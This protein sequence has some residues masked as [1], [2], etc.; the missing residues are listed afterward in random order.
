PLQAASESSGALGETPRIVRQLSSTVV[1]TYV[2]QIPGPDG[3]PLLVVV[4]RVARTSGMTDEQAAEYVSAAEAA[5]QLDHPN[6]VRARAISPGA[7][8]ISISCDFV[9]GERLAALWE[10]VVPLEIA[11]RVFI[12][13]LTG[14]SAIHKVK[15]ESGH[16][17]L[18]LIHGEMSAANILVGI[19]GVSRILRMCRVRTAEAFPRSAIG[20]LAPEILS[21]EQ[22]DQRADVFSVGALLWQAL[23]GRPLFA[24]E[25]GPDTI[26]ETIRSGGISRA[27][28]PSGADWAEPLADVTARALDIDPSKRFPTAVAM[29][30]ELRKVGGSRL[31]TTSQV[32]DFVQSVAGEKIAERRAPPRT[33]EETPAPEPKRDYPES[34][35]RIARFQ[36]LPAPAPVESCVQIDGPFLSEPGPSVSI[37]RTL[38]PMLEP[39]PI[40][41]SASS[42]SE[43]PASVRPAPVFTLLDPFEPIL[44]PEAAPPLAE[45]RDQQVVFPAG[46][47]DL[48]PMEAPTANVLDIDPGDVRSV[49]PPL[50]TTE[51]QANVAEGAVA[52][53]V[54]P[55]STPSIIE[56]DPTDVAS[57]PPSLAPDPTQ[58]EIP[59]IP[60]APAIGTVAGATEPDFLAELAVALA[61]GENGPPVSP[62]LPRPPG[63]LQTTHASSGYRKP[64]LRPWSERPVEL[65]PADLISVRPPAQPPE[66]RVHHPNSRAREASPAKARMWEQLPQDFWRTAL[67]PRSGA[68]A[69]H[70]PLPSENEP[71]PATS[72]ERVAPAAVTSEPKRERRLRA[73]SREAAPRATRLWHS[74]AQ[75]SWHKGQLLSSDLTTRLETLA[76]S[77][78]A[79]VSAIIAIVLGASGTWAAL[80]FVARPAPDPEL[81][82][83]SRDALE[84]AAPAIIQPSPAT[85]RLDVPNEFEN[86]AAREVPASAEQP[87]ESA[88]KAEQPITTRTVQDAPAIIVKQN[89]EDLTK[90]SK[91]TLTPSAMD[92]PATE[93]APRPRAVQERSADQWDSPP[94][95]VVPPPHPSFA[96]VDLAGEFDRTSAMQVLR[97]AG[98][99]ARGCLAGA[100]PPEGIRVAVTFA[101]TGSVTNIVVEGPFAGTPKGECMAAK[102]RPLRVP[103]FRGSSVTVRKTIVF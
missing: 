85:T 54:R 18:K 37:P 59:P 89:G 60:A 36:T 48:D 61:P 87:S 58:A 65:G 2:E 52:D 32:A 83:P 27:T 86:N 38:R 19:D 26:L 12:E 101:R 73:A 39:P 35:T 55:A 5:T 4:E 80:D 1:P 93:P 45:P 46:M 11:L 47:L 76:G 84:L 88:E 82:I 95:R 102:F 62:P 24:D 63:A 99:H 20:T 74:I 77:K 79:G 56:L 14:L 33:V 43:R 49:P 70:V 6:V 91:A 68:A 17:R 69:R 21:G 78:R 94:G 10:S 100:A 81:A 51:P 66:E 72:L 98:D 13:V 28:V 31:A 29:I 50:P 97:E 92:Q 44:S 7:D 22:G 41:D 42:T 103:P 30:T 40:P 8:E 71:P 64:S 75:R 3:G 53:F 9:D 67:V 34:G 25:P 16:K 57:V 90:P 23:T 96:D 15:D